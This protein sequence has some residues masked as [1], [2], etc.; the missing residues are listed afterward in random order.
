M[1]HNHAAAPE[2]VDREQWF[3]S[4]YS[5][6]EGSACVEVKRFAS[7]VGIR[8]SK[9]KSGPALMFTRSA[10]DSFM[11]EIDGLSS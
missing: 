1:I 6:G 3:K 9:D 2:T 5:G 11:N 8:D 4:S 10:W 7:G